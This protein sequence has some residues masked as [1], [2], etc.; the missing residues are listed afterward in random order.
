MAAIFP[1][2]ADLIMKVA[3]IV[4]GLGAL[5]GVAAYAY[6]TYPTVIDTGYQPVQPDV[7]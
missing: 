4:V 7:P 1:K 2:S 3:G 5:A 6:Y